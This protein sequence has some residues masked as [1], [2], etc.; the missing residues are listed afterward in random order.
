M[1]RQAARSLGPCE[2]R[3]DREESC[4]LGVDDDMGLKPFRE[5]AERGTA[6]CEM[7]EERGGN[8]LRKDSCRVSNRVERVESSDESRE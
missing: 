2:E 3:P 4:P 8:D 6:V 7:E 5:D 1:E